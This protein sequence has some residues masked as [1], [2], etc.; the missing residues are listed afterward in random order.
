MHLAISSTKSSSKSK[1]RTST[2]SESISSKYATDEINA[3]IAIRNNL[4]VEAEGN[5]TSGTLKRV[6]LANEFVE[7]RLKPARS[8]YQTQYLPE[9]DAFRERQHCQSVKNRLAELSKL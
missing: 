6:G 4:L 5:P 7:T 8:P 2:S 1:A 9:A 3:Y